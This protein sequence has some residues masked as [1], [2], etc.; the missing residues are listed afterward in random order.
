MPL[1]GGAQRTSLDALAQALSKEVKDSGEESF[2][3][4]KTGADAVLELKFEIVK[5]VIKVRLDEMELRQNA[6][7]LKAQERKLD[8]LIADKEDEALKA[9]S[10]DDLKKMREALK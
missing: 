5:R 9:M 4:K 6:A 7:T 8:G 10:V 2:V 1:T 3:T